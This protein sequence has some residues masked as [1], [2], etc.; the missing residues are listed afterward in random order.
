M[1]EAIK[2]LEKYFPV[3]VSEMANYDEPA[4]VRFSSVITGFKSDKDSSYWYFTNHSP[5]IIAWLDQEIEN[6][7]ENLIQHIFGGDVKHL[8]KAINLLRSLNWRGEAVTVYGMI[9]ST[10]DDL[11]YFQAFYIFPQIVQAELDKIRIKPT[12]KLLVG[13]VSE[14]AAKDFQQRKK[15]ISGLLRRGLNG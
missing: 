5:K 7:T 14:K 12:E 11:V 3:A 6:L 9:I 2:E 8:E 10:E 15:Q 4:L 1:E 13:K